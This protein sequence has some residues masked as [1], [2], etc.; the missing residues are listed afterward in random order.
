MKNY[1][2]LFMI[3]IISFCYTEAIAQP[4]IETNRPASATFQDIKQSFNDYWKDK[5]I[6]R[7]RGYKQFKRWEWFWESRLMPNGE[8]P[9]PTITMDEYRKYYE[10]YAAKQ[11]P[12]TL[13][14]D[15][16]EFAGPL[17]APIKKNVGLG[18]LNCVAF[19]PT[20]K[21]IFWVGSPSGG[22]WKTT[23]G[24]V[25]WSTNTDDLPVL[26]VSDIAI[27]P[28]NP[29]IMYIATGDGDNAGG[30]F[31]G[32][33]KSIGVLKSTNGGSTWRG[34]GLS[35]TVNELKLIRR[36]LIHPNNPQQLLAAAS[37]GI[38]MTS[39]GGKT[40]EKKQS[41]RFIDLESHPTDPSIIYASTYAIPYLADTV[42]NIYRS[43]DTGSSWTS[44]ATLHGVRRIDMAVSKH[45]PNVVQALCADLNGGLS[46]IWTSTDNGTSFTETFVG[47][48]STNLL[49][50]SYNASGIGGQGW[51]DLALA[52]NPF[53]VNEMWVGGINTW[54]S[55]DGAKTWNLKTMWV[56]DLSLNPNNV[57]NVHA[58]KHFYMYH[59]LDSGV[60][61]ECNDGGL[62]KTTNSG[63]NWIDLSSGLGISQIYRIGVAQTTELVIAGLQDNGNK[64]REGD[65]WSELPFGG[66]GMNCIVDYSDDRYFYWS[67]QNGDIYSAD[68]TKSPV[69]INAISYNIPDGQQENTSP[70]G[71]WI[72]PYVIHP[73]NPKVLYAGYKRIFK[74]TD[75]GDSWTAISPVLTSD[76]LQYIA[77]SATDENTL[78]AATP[79]SLFSTTDGGQNWESKSIGIPSANISNIAVD[80][81]NSKRLYITISGYLE[82][83]KV[84]V[85]AD[86]GDN[87]YNYSGSLPNVPVNCIVY[88][89]GSNE[90]LYIGTDIGVFYTDASMT[91]WIPYQ[92]GLPNVIVNDLEISY[93]DNTLWAGTY[94]RGLWATDL[95]MAAV[96]IETQY[97]N[98]KVDIFPNPNS[99]TFSIE[100]PDTKVYDIT[101]H[102]VHGELVFEK[103]QLLSS[104]NVIDLNHVNSGVYIV[105]LK[106]DNTSISRKIIINK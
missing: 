51:Y 47:T 91:D 1:A 106:I 94:G 29:N 40:W 41:G 12:R 70:A 21:Q 100:V 73:T 42:S 88:Q 78:Y 67:T 35:S 49:N 76:V 4:W 7:G 99:G 20:D 58:D 6:E 63:E 38:W 31:F 87:W 103:H 3:V 5:Q 80:P 25:T 101:V 56:E 37:D 26:G 71:A 11:S 74:T 22:L 45:S 16:W 97:G 75:R 81:L 27:D 95:N 33:T 102:N 57:P 17:V 52:I 46:G 104:Q 59:P 96:G 53:N 54:K 60:L 15:D 48:E 55:N 19:H 28:T 44:V 50:T 13:S 85:S 66:D 82:G 2:I 93:R 89:Q 32:D 72:T 43:T 9:S 86:G 68:L 77:T 34:T 79:D 83:K 8:F 84:F 61:F 10:M 14:S 98:S 62:Y 30:G 24:G 105:R 69:E 23:D 65:E 39:N 36:L 90:G 18:R 92:N 64:A